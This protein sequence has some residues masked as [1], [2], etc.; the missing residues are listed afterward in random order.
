ME[1]DGSCAP[2]A[3]VGGTAARVPSG[4]PPAVRPFLSIE[5]AQVGSEHFEECLEDVLAACDWASTE[6]ITQPPR[7]THVLLVGHSFGA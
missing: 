4:E 7:Q 2:G 6:L 5:T 3:R 1:W